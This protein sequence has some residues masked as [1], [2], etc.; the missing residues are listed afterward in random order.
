MTSTTSGERGRF[1][2]P[3]LYL[4][5]IQTGRADVFRNDN[6]RVDGF[7]IPHGS[8]LRR[9]LVEHGWRPAGRGAGDG[10]W[11]AIVVEPLPRH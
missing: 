1:G 5:H 11:G 6:T 8:N 9:V 10:A 3:S 4:A 7:A 2:L